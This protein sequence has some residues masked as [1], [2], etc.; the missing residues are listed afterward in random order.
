MHIGSYIYDGKISYGVKVEGGIFDLGGRLNKH[1]ADLPSLI[2]G[3]ALDQAAKVSKGESADFTEDDVIF[4]P[5]MPA[6]VNIYCTGIN[7]LDHIT[8]TKRD[9]PEFPT[10]FLKTHQSMVGHMQ[11][12]VRPKISQQFDFEGELAIVIGKPGRY[13]K[14]E[15]WQDYIAGYTILMDGSIRDFQQ[16]SVDQ[17]KNFYRSSSSGPWMVTID[18]APKKFS[19]M[20]LTTKLNGQVMQSSDAGQL[21]FGIPELLS[22]FSQIFYFQPGDIIATGTPG[23][24]GSK[25]SPPVWMKSGDQLEV[26]ISG[27]GT[28]KNYI[29][30]EL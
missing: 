3:F 17:G 14:K 29:V 30:D 8:E 16:I 5:I 21:C 28:L 18:E 12:L 20:K 22:Y 23:G 26:E 24:V 27:I 2:R 7:Y 4:V 15:N 9:R 1:Y 6:P 13:I 11:P 19:S 25:R 10:L